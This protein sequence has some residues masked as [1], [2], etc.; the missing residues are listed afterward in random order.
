MVFYF[1]RILTAQDLHGIDTSTNLH[2]TAQ[3]S[4]RCIWPFAVLPRMSRTAFRNRWS[5][6]RL[7]I[8]VQLPHLKL[9][10][11]SLLLLHSSQI[12]LM[13]VQEVTFEL[14]FY[15]FEAKTTKEIS[16]GIGPVNLQ[17][18]LRWAQTASDDTLGPLSSSQVMLTHP[19]P[20]THSI[21]CITGV[22]P[23]TA[24][25]KDSDKNRAVLPLVHSFFL[26]RD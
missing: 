20:P 8:N 19:K 24:C 22:K 18:C 12:L 25:E 10:T 7:A 14:T 21:H 6:F 15:F 4:G 13:L 26:L 23:L 5:P 17:R 9:E 3:H 2:C 1:Y 16:S 11:F